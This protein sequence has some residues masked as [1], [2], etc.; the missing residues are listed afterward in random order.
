MRSYSSLALGL[1]ITVQEH[2]NR[3]EWEWEGKRKGRITRN[4][5]LLTVR[6]YS[7]TYSPIWFL[8]CRANY[9]QLTSTHHMYSGTYDQTTGRQV[10]WIC[11]LLWGGWYLLPCGN[12]VC[13]QI[14]ESRAVLRKL[15]AWGSL[16][17]LFPG[18]QRKAEE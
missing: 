9:M 1:V 17:L 5:L 8:Q 2:T 16:L 10:G 7:T 15:R 11:W 18:G 13:S 6:R 3:T 4:S 12:S 14:S